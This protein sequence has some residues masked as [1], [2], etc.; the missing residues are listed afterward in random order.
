MVFGH[1]LGGTRRRTGAALALAGALTLL[2]GCAATVHEHHYF[3]AFRQGQDEAREPVQFYR[4][5]VDGQSFLANTRYLTGYFDERAVSLLFNEMRSLGGGKLFEDSVGEPGE[6]AVKLKPLSPAG[7]DG[8]FVLIMSTHA[9]AIAGT[10]GSFAESQV[11]A[12]SLTRMLNRE[13]FQSKTTSD[14]T[15]SLRQ[16]QATALVTQ[17][18]AF[19]G[20]ASG[21]GSGKAAAGSYRSALTTLA[22]SLGYT[23]PAFSSFNDARAWFEIEAARAGEAK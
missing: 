8:A 19:A 16:A 1:I 23:G 11:V 9:D 17:V 5:S 18:D 22:A 13:R 20:A 4:M 21:A 14:A 10:I 12:D 7:A 15:L 2:A 3:A 6:S